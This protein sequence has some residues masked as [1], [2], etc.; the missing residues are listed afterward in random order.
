[1]QQR[2]TYSRDVVSNWIYDENLRLFMEALAH[3]AGATFED[4]DWI[5]LE[6]DL[7]LRR[8]QPDR[9]R[10]VE[11]PLGER[12]VHLFYEPGSSAVSFHIEADREFEIRADTLVYPL[13]RVIRQDR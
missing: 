6:H 1:M 4:D 13:Q 5:G 3:F 12:V 2:K 7:F 9:E 10:R 11:W 8:D